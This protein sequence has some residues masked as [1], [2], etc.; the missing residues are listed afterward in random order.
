MSESRLSVLVCRGCC[1]GTESKHPG[2]DHGSQLARL[3]ASMPS[4]RR[5]RLWTVD[6]LGSCE[7]SNVV[8]VRTDR[9]RRW[10]GEML[11]DVDIDELGTWFGAGA[12]G[13]VPV[14]LADREFTPS[15]VTTATAR[16]T[17]WNSNQILS[18]AEQTMNDG[19]GSWSIGVHGA[20]A[21]VMV[22][23]EVPSVVRNANSLVAE[24]STGSIRL[25]IDDGIY[26]FAIDRPDQPEQPIA[27]ILAV[28]V[29]G[30]APSRR[31]VTSRGPD[32]GAIR[33]SDRNDTLFDLGLGRSNISFCI[34]TGDD[35]LLAEL[36]SVARRHWRDALDEIG[37]DLIARSP[38]R[39]VE[40]V[41]G[42]AEVYTE[43]PHVGS[44]PPGGAHTHLLDGELDLGLDLPPGITLPNGF[45]PSALLFPNDR[46]VHPRVS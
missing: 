43:I 45:V 9:G 15:V 23:A 12:P 25:G 40:S 37:P 41:I 29:S 27:V 35:L 22:D 18:M 7:H 26:A 3:Q 5:A 20:S 39:V 36:R 38:H 21:E 34:R 44:V 32:V 11:D 16:L 30:L 24:S 2:V 4:H 31:T 13:D 10:F 8:V 17:G 46:W 28:L 6:C 19:G 33:P 42:R 14:R 1:C